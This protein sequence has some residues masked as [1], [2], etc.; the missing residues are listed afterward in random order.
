[1]L[2]EDLPL[3]IFVG[4]A[5][6]VVFSL[7][8][9]GPEWTLL[10]VATAPLVADVIKHYVVA[11]GWGKRR[12][13]FLTVLLVFFGRVK[14]ALA[15]PFRSSSSPPRRTNGGELGRPRWYSVAATAAVAS[16]LTI[17]FFSL[18]EAASGDALLADRRWTV[19]PDDDNRRA[20]L[21]VRKQG[22]GTV[23][24]TP[25]GIDCGAVCS[26]TYRRS[27]TVVLTATAEPRSVFAGWDGGGCTGTSSC[28]VGMHGDVAVTARF[29]PVEQT[30]PLTVFKRG[31]GTG[32]VSSDPTGVDC[33]DVCRAS[34]PIGA[35]IV[36]V[37][38]AAPGSI[39]TGW[40]GGGCAGVG[41]CAVAMG[42]PRIVDA[43]FRRARGDTA[44]LTID[45]QGD[46]GGKVVSEP[47]GI[48]CEPTCSSEFEAGS[49]V[50][51]T[52]QAE[53]GSTFDGWSGGGC[54]GPEPCVV[55]LGEDTTVAATF[56]PAATAELAVRLRGEGSVSSRPSGI[57]CEPIC[58]AS[59]QVGSTVVLTASAA[60]GWT[61]LG[62][63]GAGCSGRGLCRVTLD[64]PKLVYARFRPAPRTFT[65]TVS[66]VEDGGSGIV[67]SSPGGI[68]C[69][70][71]C[72]T[73]F[74]AGR[75]V[76][77]T[78]AED[79]NSDFYGF[80]GDCAGFSCTVTMSG[81]RSVS[82]TFRTG[83][84]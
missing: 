32:T 7:V 43:G 26:A 68:S 40:R 6:A 18:V 55:T 3:T 1:V 30:V 84:D 66:I 4:V 50:T 33:G 42:S 63:N 47:S 23:T 54:T 67:T 41:S 34:Y 37:A 35:R 48:D 83:V 19:W 82:A 38:Q 2:S 28:Q 9:L 75:M 20:Q 58:M 24:A 65:L 51:L 11:K 52:A 22:Q 16:G 70:P 73:S 64:G 8:D 61:F 71:S 46:G 39:F 59:F 13:A 27:L 10:G 36:L 57:S 81:N 31:N 53:D 62:W 49:E 21:E 76:T 44:R 15:R 5:T 45:L 69:E 14:E 60:D 78:A 25:E 72:S 17:A 29:R 79:S 12:L 56:K 74:T 80:G 77:L